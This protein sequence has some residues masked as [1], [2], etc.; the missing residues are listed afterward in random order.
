MRTTTRFHRVL[1]IHSVLC[2]REVLLLLSCLCASWSRVLI[3]KLS[4]FQLLKKVPAFYEIQRFITTFTRARRLSLSWATSIQ[5][6]TPH[7]TCWRSILL[8]TSHLTPG[9]PSGIF[10][11][12]FPTKILY[13]S[14]LSPYVLMPRPLHYSRFYH[15]NNIW[16]GV[17]SS[18]CAFLRSPV[19]SSLWDPNIL[20]YTRFTNTL[21]LLSFLNVSDKVLFY[22]T[23][24]LKYIQ[25]YYT[26][27]REL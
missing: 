22:G 11:A 20:L 3:E 27:Q 5:S 15:L 16:W 9:L 4:G 23:V 14:I 13:T 21:S 19:T 6:I 24:S 18:L 26:Y 1:N 8:L 12:D 25:N 2:L 10:F 7:P 17:S